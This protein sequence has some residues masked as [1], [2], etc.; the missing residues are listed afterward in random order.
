MPDLC[1]AYVWGTPMPPISWNEIRS[2]AVAFSQEYKNA[3]RENAEAQSFYND[4]FNVFGISRRRVA[5]FEEPVRK[6]GAKRG[7]IDLFWKGVLLAEQKSAG[8]DLENAYSQALDYFRGN[9]IQ[10]AESLGIS[11][12]TLQRRLKTWGTVEAVGLRRPR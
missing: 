7:R 3:T 6:L 9:R 1:L 4:F 8:V 12:R 5:S 2:R 10:A 11:V